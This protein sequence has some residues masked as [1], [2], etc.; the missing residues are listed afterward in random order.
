MCCETIVHH[1]YI[2]TDS[3]QPH[4]GLMK[5][6]KNYFMILKE[7]ENFSSLS[8]LLYTSVDF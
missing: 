2:S 7:T 8:S 4:I 5:N 3:I 1:K 6:D